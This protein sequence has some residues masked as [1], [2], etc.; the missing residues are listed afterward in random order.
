MESIELGDR[1]LSRHMQV[2]RASFYA[3]RGPCTSDLNGK[4]LYY[5]FKD[6]HDVD[7]SY[8]ENFI[9]LVDSI[10]SIGA[11]EFI[12][13]YNEFARNDFV[14]DNG[15]VSDEPVIEGRTDRERMQSAVCNGLGALGIFSVNDTPEQAAMVSNNIKDHFYSLTRRY[16][17]DEFGVNPFDEE[18]VNIS[19]DVHKIIDPYFRRRSE[20]N[21]EMARRMKA[22]GY[23]DLYEETVK[24]LVKEIKGEK[25]TREN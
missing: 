2:T 9:R 5:I 14:L 7:R 12:N 18:N 19:K 22:D 17:E 1:I 24:R 13:A 4:M 20:Y 15:V 8:G 25:E 11:T 21:E 6:L 23:A 10:P 16:Y 3:G